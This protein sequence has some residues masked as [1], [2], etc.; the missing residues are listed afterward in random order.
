MNKEKLYLDTSAII[1]EFVPEEIGSDLIIKLVNL[2]IKKKIQIVTST[3]TI[4]EFLA[5]IDKKIEVV[6]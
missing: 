1:K 2:A 4:N 5:V 3:W 6:T